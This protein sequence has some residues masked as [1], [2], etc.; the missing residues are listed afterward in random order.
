MRMVGTVGLVDEHRGERCDDG[1][2]AG[3]EP[4]WRGKGERGL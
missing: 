1:R 4:E 2:W 3:V